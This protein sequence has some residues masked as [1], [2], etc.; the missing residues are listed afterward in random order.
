MTLPPRSE[1]LSAQLLASFDVDCGE[2]VPGQRVIARGLTDEG[3]WPDALGNEPPAEAGGT[4]QMVSLEY[5]LVPG[6]TDEQID[7]APWENVP[8]VDAVYRTDAPLAWSTGGEHGGMASFE[9]PPGQVKAIGQCGPYPLPPEA[10]QVSFELFAVLDAQGSRVWASS[11]PV[12][13]V[14]VDV[15]SGTAHWRP[16]ASKTE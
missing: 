8:I 2:L 15:A 14:V 6:F 4:W 10:E 7:A 1:R 12:G 3:T 9:T 13:A 5:E 16:A 11:R